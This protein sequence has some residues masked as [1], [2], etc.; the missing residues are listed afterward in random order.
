M[1][2]VM[3]LAELK[4]KEQFYRKKATQAQEDAKMCLDASR[5]CEDNLDKMIFLYMSECLADDCTYFLERH[6]EYYKGMLQLLDI[7]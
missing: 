1:E 7:N 3:T 6:E 2:S 4:A 5:S